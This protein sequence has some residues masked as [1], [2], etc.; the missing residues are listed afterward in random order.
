MSDDESD[1]KYSSSNDYT[2]YDGV[3]PK[4]PPFSTRNLIRVNYKVVSQLSQPILL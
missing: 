2:G 1:E 3:Q 4:T